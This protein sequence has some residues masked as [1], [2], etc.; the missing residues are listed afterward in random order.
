MW[1]ELTVSSATPGQL[2]LGAL[3]KQAEEAWRQHLVASAL[4]HALSSCPAF[5]G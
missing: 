1:V 5:L 2:V 4:V 3:R